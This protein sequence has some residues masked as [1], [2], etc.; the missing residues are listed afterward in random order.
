[1]T[2]YTWRILF[3]ILFTMTGLSTIFV[4]LAMESKLFEPTLVPDII[5]GVILLW[6]LSA[7]AGLIAMA[8]HIQQ[9]PRYE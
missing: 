1:M 3:P 9:G 8:E 5:A 7:V 4:N 6:A 2:N